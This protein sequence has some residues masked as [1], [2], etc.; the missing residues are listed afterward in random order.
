MFR[1]MLNKDDPVAKKVLAYTDSKEFKQELDKLSE[2]ARL[3]LTPEE[4]K[5][6]KEGRGNHEIQ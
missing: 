4:Y 3:G 1:D 6:Y 5:K 2:R